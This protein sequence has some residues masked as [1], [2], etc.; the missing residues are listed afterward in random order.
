ME[1]QGHHTA[2]DSYRV[3]LSSLVS[4]MSRAYTLFQSSKN[5]QKR[6]LINFM[7]SNLKL[8]GVKL[9]YSLRSPF[10]LM[11]NPQSYEEWLP[12]PDSNQRP[13]D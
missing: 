5:E 2:D 8:E 13:I 11:V 1:L 3:T 12:G 9:Q 7:F 10:H 4:L 6:Q